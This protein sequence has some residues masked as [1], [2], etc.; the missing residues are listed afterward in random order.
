MDFLDDLDFLDFLDFLDVLDF[1][2]DLDFLCYG[3]PTRGT[4]YGRGRA[5]HTRGRR[6]EGRFMGRMGGMG[7]MGGMG[8]LGRM[9]GRYQIKK[10]TSMKNN[11]MKALQGVIRF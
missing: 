3:H 9:G 10:R 8:G 1:L 4:A 5:R 11:F 6:D 7:K 2:D